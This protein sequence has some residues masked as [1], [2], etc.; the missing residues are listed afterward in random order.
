[1][2]LRLAGALCAGLL[3]AVLAPRAALA[4]ETPLLPRD[5]LF[6]NPDRQGVRLSATGKHVTWLAPVDGVMNLWIA[7]RADLAAAKPLTR[8]T[9]RGISQYHWAYDDAH[10]LYRQDRDGDENWRIY[11]LDV[12]TGAVKDLTPLEKVSAR[13]EGASPEHPTTIVVGLNDRDP[14]YHDL[15]KIDVVSGERTPLLQN[16]GFTGFEVDW[17]F[18]VRY[19]GRTKPGGGTSILRRTDEG[20][21]EPWLE[22]DHEDAGTGPAGFDREGKV[23]YFQDSRDRDTSALFAIDTAT[24]ER[25]LLAEDP[26]ADVG[27]RIVHPS[28]GRIQAVSVTW[29]R[30]RWKVVDPAIQPHLDALAK[31][32]AGSLLV[33]DRTMDDTT[34]VV[35]FLHDDAPLR[36]HLYD[37]ATKKATF[38]FTNRKALEGVPLS[39]MHSVVI[40]SRDGLDL[41]SYLTLPRASDPD[42]DG[43]PAAPLPL[44]LLVHGGPW[45]RDGWGLDGAHQWLA[46]R[47]YAVLAVNF[48]GSSGFGKRFLNAADGEWAGKMHDDLLDAVEWA[49]A[50][51][52]ADRARVAIMGGSY[53]GYATLVGLT[54]TPDVFACGVDIVGPSSLVTLLESVPPYWKPQ[55]EQMVRRIGDHRTEEGR[56]R[57]LER[58]PL[59]HVEKIRRPLLIGQGANDPRVKKAESDQ[60]VAAMKAKGIPVVYCLYPD[61]GHGFARPPNRL[62]FYAVVE[63]FLAPILGGRFEPIGDARKGSSLEVVTGAEL[64]PGLQ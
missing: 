6:G 41:V 20:T 23:L 10:V 17:Q 22:I 27:S 44:V 46:N 21:F 50:G 34:W 31:V 53:G 25:K 33:A 38:L 16:E 14:R 49:V 42:G 51:K 56:K 26:K 61:E 47:G 32:D 63:S 18:R 29:D 48:R 2:R 55:L 35:A 5:L 57:L 15:W 39:P 59:T 24:N 62:S 37:T 11:S 54:F 19:A 12:A 60:I 8:D 45:A 58:S 43:R 28:T 36:Y 1:M 30:P 64:V 7:P 9:G 3:A 4:E 13:I 40:R 52:V